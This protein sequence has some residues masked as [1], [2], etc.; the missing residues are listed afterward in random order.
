IPTGNDLDCSESTCRP[1]LGFK[2][3]SPQQAAGIRNE[4]PPS[5]AWA[6]GTTPAATRAAEPPDEAPVEKSRFQG[7]RAGA[8]WAGSVVA[9][10]PNSGSL[11][12][13]RVINP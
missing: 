8:P 12:L 6:I 3:T 11:L 1:R 9:L 7:F 5:L 10:K 13:P 4:P 2:P